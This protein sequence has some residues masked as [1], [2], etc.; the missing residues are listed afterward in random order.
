MDTII[1]FLIFL[2]LVAVWTGRRWLVI[3]MFLIALAATLLWFRH[4]ATDVLPLN[5]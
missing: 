5:F 1:F 2:V 3:P 4:H